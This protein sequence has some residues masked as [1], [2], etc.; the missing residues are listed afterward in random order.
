MDAVTKEEKIIHVDVMKDE[1][2]SHVGVMKD[3]RKDAKRDVA[4]DAM[5][6]IVTVVAAAMIL[7]FRRETI[8]I[9]KVMVHVAAKSHSCSCNR[10][11]EEE[12]PLFGGLFFMV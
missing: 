1:K 8:Q 12:S 4:K 3:E 10:M 2:I 5:I 11:Y 7:L 6:M 9:S